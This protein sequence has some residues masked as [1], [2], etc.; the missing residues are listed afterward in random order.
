[1]RSAFRLGC[2]RLAAVTL[3]TG[4]ALASESWAVERSAVTARTVRAAAPAV[5]CGTTLVPIDPAVDL[6]SAVAA[7]WPRTGWPRSV[8]TASGR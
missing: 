5:V 7:C 3:I 2:T 6:T 8:T 4:P 1:M